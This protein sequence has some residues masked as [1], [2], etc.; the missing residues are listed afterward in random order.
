VRQLPF[1]F[2][3]KLTESEDYGNI[4]F[5]AHSCSVTAIMCPPV[6]DVTGSISGSEHRLKQFVILTGAADGSV[7]IWRCDFLS[8][9][10]ISSFSLHSGPVRS[11]V[12]L[13]NT[14]LSPFVSDSEN[15]SHAPQL[16]NNKGLALSIGEDRSVA[17]YSL[18]PPHCKQVMG[19]HSSEIVG[20]E[21][22]EDQDYIIVR[23]ADNTY[24]LWDLS[25]GQMHFHT[26][27]QPVITHQSNNSHST[28][29][30]HTFMMGA[31]SHDLLR[32]D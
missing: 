29:S 2:K 30:D 10:L 7:K 6:P 17:L 31:V 1:P 20:I 19:K 18:R 16:V 4:D 14:S 28:A 25:T 15:F 13:P 26:H 3:K 32:F 12:S 11:L 5:R 9:S 27:N 8:I 21:A 23:C 22:R 24:T